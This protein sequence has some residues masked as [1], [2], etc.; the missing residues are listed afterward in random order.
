MQQHIVAA[1][2]LIRTA[3]RNNGAVQGEA[4]MESLH[5]FRVFAVVVVLV[6]VV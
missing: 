4:T 6:N 5:R 1:Q 2:R 3:I